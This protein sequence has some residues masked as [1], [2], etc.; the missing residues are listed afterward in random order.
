MPNPRINHS[1]SRSN[2]PLLCS[3]HLTSPPPSATVELKVGTTSVLPRPAADETA[4]AP[5]LRYLVMALGS[6]TLRYGT[7]EEFQPRSKA[8]AV[9]YRVKGADS[10]KRRRRAEE[11]ADK[12]TKEEAKEEQKNGANGT[13]LH[14]KNDVNGD[15]LMK[16]ERKQSQ[17]S[18]VT[19]AGRAEFTAQVAEWHEQAG[20]DF[21]ALNG[22]VIKRRVQPVSVYRNRTNPSP[23]HFRLFLSADML[24]PS[25]CLLDLTASQA[26]VLR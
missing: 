13:V 20:E 10:R 18:R 5:H 19:L 8:M 21:T 15:A 1:H 6:S 23:T 2:H 25:A 16:D 12:G 9:A 17:R 7:A 4:A 26:Q 11:A 14:E 22:E 3:P 24:S